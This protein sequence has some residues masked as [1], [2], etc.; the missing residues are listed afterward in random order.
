MAERGERD[1]G[2]GDRK[3]GSQA[4]TPIIDDF[5]ISKTQSS[6]WQGR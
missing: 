3:S 5:G 4:A 2:H 1:R 6:R